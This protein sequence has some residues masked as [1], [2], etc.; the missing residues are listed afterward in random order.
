MERAKDTTTNIV[1]GSV[2]LYSRSVDGEHRQEYIVPPLWEACNAGESVNV[3]V[4][5]GYGGDAKVDVCAVGD[6][7][8]DSGSG[9]G[10]QQG[11]MHVF[12]RSGAKGAWVTVAESPLGASDGFAYDRF[13]YAVDMSSDGGILVAGAH[14]KKIDPHLLQGAAYVFERSPTTG[15]LRQTAA[16]NHPD[17]QPGDYFGM[18]VAAA[19]LQGLPYAAFGAP[20]R[21]AQG[22]TVQIGAAYVYTRDIPDG[23]PWRLVRTLLPANTGAD[24]LAHIRFGFALRFDPAANTLHVGAP[25]WAQNTSPDGRAA[26]ARFVYSAANWDAAPQV[27]SP[28]SPYASRKY[29]AYLPHDPSLIQ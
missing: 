25:Y 9:T 16:L 3:V 28:P 29:G 10:T 7:L 19:R 22:S 11:R 14:A 8:G 18:A 4:R 6:M 24:S 26:G 12:T 15:R 27:I 13:A 20:M 1:I 23:S 21:L 5:S 2:Y 17:G